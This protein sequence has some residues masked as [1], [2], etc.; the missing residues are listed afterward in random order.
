MRTDYM[1]MGVADGAG[2]R[3]D[4]VDGRKRVDTEAWWWRMS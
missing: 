1:L 2:G 3:D 4:G